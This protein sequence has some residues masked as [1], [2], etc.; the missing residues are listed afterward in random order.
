MSRAG[1]ELQSLDNQ[2]FGSH[3]ASDQIVE[4][5]QGI[6]QQPPQAQHSLPPTDEGYQAWLLLAGC[7]IINVL[8]WG[9]AFSF[10]VLQEYYTTHEPFKSQPKGIAA[11]G[12]TATGKLP[13][14]RSI[15]FHLDLCGF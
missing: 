6:H 11:I 13:T 7:F 5:E 9:F 4:R 10:G 14:R 15:P 8:V 2:V 1:T 3:D 12:T